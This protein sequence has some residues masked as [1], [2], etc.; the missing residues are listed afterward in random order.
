MVALLLATAAGGWLLG[1]EQAGRAVP[2]RAVAVA[3]AVGHPLAQTLPATAEALTRAS[4]A[5]DLRQSGTDPAEIAPPD[6]SALGYAL[7]RTRSVGGPR[8]RMT[9][10]R[11][12]RADGHR[13]SLFIHRRTPEE[14]RDIVFSR[15]GT[16]ATARWL[17]GPLVYGVVGER[18]RVRA[19]RRRRDDPGGGRPG[20]LRAARIADSDHGRTMPLEESGLADNAGRAAPTPAIALPT[21][22]IGTVRP[23]P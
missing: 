19:L 22:G 8:Q 17:D 23:M 16:V 21:D 10:L 3:G 15:N 5:A 18:Q 2:A 11:Y 13:L 7:D 9:E 4:T 12:V 20:A 14:D 1:H 6:L